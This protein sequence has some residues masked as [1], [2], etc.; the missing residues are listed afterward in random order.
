W[1]ARVQ[2]PLLSLTSPERRPVQAGPV[3]N[4]RRIAM[5]RTTLPLLAGALSLAM[6]ACSPGTGDAADPAQPAG[7][8]PTEPAAAPTTAMTP[9][10]SAPAAEDRCDAS[11]AQSL[12]GQQATEDVVEQARSDAGADSAR[13]LH[14]DQA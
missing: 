4:R 13:T 5:P 3:R 6:A 7:I 12:V 9:A 1:W 11:A 14:P 2:F 8:P 10:T